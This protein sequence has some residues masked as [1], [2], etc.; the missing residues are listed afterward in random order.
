[1]GQQWCMGCGVKGK[2][3]PVAILLL[4]E[5]Y[6]IPCARDGG[7][8]EPEIAAAPKIVAQASSPTR[9][10]GYLPGKQKPGAKVEVKSAGEVEAAAP[11][12]PDVQVAQESEATEEEPMAN[13]SCGKP[14]RHRG[15]CLSARKVAI[16]RGRKRA[17]AQANGKER[18]GGASTKQATVALSVAGNGNGHALATET[19][20]T[21]RVS[22]AQMV[23]MFTSLSV[24]D[25][26]RL[27]Q[28]CLEWEA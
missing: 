17:S 6:C 20:A 28:T 13:C 11:V 27:L 22:E 12:V 25:K 15:R 1:M 3:T 14:A 9:P 4:G 8:G 7:V 24:E 16:E 2:A 26:A 5:P 21:L 10:A 18:A 23:R 19:T